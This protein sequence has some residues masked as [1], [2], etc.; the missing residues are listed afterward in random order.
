MSNIQKIDLGILF[1]SDIT[2]RL[3]FSPVNRCIYRNRQT[4]EGFSTLISRLDPGRDIP[5]P[6]FSRLV[7]TTFYAA[8]IWWMDGHTGNVFLPRTNLESDQAQEPLLTYDDMHPDYTIGTS[9]RGTTPRIITDIELE[10]VQKVN[11]GIL[12]IMQDKLDGNGAKLS[13]Y[14]DEYDPASGLVHM[15][16]NRAPHT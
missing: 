14:T 3:G 6:R 12:A 15:F 16:V 1:G 9:I 11:S 5:N 8:A 2:H 4:T 10:I 13:M 7:H